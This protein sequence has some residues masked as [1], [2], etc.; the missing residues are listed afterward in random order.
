MKQL[1]YIYIVLLTA[2]ICDAQCIE[3]RESLKK[4]AKK[5]LEVNK[6]DLQRELQFRKNIW[7][8]ENKGHDPNLIM[9]K[10]IETRLP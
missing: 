2:T 9:H 1:L 5:M 3:S 8:N 7:I 4:F 10:S 6:R